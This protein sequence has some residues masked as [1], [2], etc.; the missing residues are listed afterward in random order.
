M[1]PQYIQD[2]EKEL[3]GSYPNTYTYTKSMAERSMKVR[4]GNLK[5]AIVRPSIV[6]GAYSEPLPGWV[7][8]LTAAGGIVFSFTSGL[9]HYVPCDGSRICDCI[10]VDFTSNMILAAGVFTALSPG[11]VLNVSHNASSHSNPVS[12]RKLADDCMSYT[13]YHPYHRQLFPGHVRDCGT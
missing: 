11:P 10:P 5:C 12:L 4:L 13:D 1:N 2:H 8:S 3:I 7:D 9:M 6:I